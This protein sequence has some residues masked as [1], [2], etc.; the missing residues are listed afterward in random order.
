MPS[1]W[2]GP[3]EAA[4]RRDPLPC[5]RH[6]AAV[7]GE[8]RSVSLWDIINRSEGAGLRGAARPV[9]VSE[10]AEPV[11]VNSRRPAATEG[12]ERSEGG[13]GAERST[14]HR[15]RSDVSVP[16]AACNSRRVSKTN[17]L[18]Q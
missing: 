10:S 17:Q 5:S 12:S 4:S 6:W 18:T 16:P 8:G 9:I 11:P 14:R 7:G 3:S 15:A 2:L 13:A 1:G